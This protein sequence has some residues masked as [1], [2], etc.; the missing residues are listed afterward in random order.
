MAAVIPRG[1]ERHWWPGHAYSALAIYILSLLFPNPSRPIPLLGLLAFVHALETLV[2]SIISPASALAGDWLLGLSW[3]ANPAAWAA[4]VFLHVGRTR[5]AILS[6]ALA[7]LLA[8]C[9]LR[10]H[11]FCQYVWLA[12]M[13]YVVCAALRV[14]DNMSGADNLIDDKCQPRG[15]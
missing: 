10:P 3:L 5:L 13:V 8:F 1:K 4:M 6:G 15:K 12:S 2:R 14:P 11:M 7:L 9:A